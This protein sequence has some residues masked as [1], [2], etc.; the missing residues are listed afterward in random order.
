M[1]PSSG[2]LLAVSDLHVTHSKNRAI[3]EWLWPESDEDW[4]IVAG[5]E[6]R[7]RYLVA[8]CRRLGVITPEDPYPVW[9][10]SGGPAP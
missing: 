8:M 5:D 6:R 3:L 1:S 4:L 2:S 9:T 7:Y 10:G